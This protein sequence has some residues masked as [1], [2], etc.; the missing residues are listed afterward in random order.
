MER[1]VATIA[2]AKKAKISTHT[3]TWSVTNILEQHTY[4]IEISTHTLTWSVTRDSIAANN[5]F[6]ISTHTLTWSVT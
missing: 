6:V 4:T 3:L 5:I 2:S 1:D